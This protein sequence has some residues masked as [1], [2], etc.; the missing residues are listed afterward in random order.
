MSGAPAARD[1]GAAPLV[2]IGDVL[3]DRDVEGTVERL[4][5]DAPVPVLDQHAVRSRPGGAG[6]AAALA[7]ADG[8]AR[9]EVTL[10]TALAGDDAGRELA[11]LLAAAG[12][13]VVDL[14][15]TGTTPE[16][17]R[18]RAAGRPLLRVDRGGAAGAIGP[19]TAAARAAIGW[20][21]ALLVADY[22]RG[23]TA[24]PA[25]RAAIAERAAEGV[26]VAWDPHPRGSAPVPGAALV[27][28]NEREA[29][30]FAPGVPGEDLRATATRAARLRARWDAAAVCVTR[31]RDGALLDS[32]GEVPLAIPAAHLAAGD[33]CGAGDRFAARAAALLAD[34]ASA[35]EAV[36][37]AVAAASAFVAAGGAAS[38]RP[39]AAPA[40]AAHAGPDGVAPPARRP[41]GDPPPP[42][43]L[44][45]ALAAVAATRAAGGVVVATGGCFDLLHAGH[46]DTLQAARGL[47]DCL[48]VCVNSDASVRR[49]KGPARPLVAAAERAA[50][51]A[52]LAC[53]DAVAV[54]DEDTPL[55]ILDRLRP[56][57]WC[58]GGDYAG[59]RLP[60]AA[61]L[62]RWGGQAV[63]LPHRAGRS[64][65]R[66][67]E[68]AVNRAAS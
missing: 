9:R 30:G 32:G 16:K 55:A 12:V 11:A 34:G 57:I 59:A 5:P 23:V 60:E 18:L 39:R 58:K 28:P 35:E 62:A 27:T 48:V 67:I 14:G 2:V 19:A 24:A 6:L 4:S 66:L 15:L 49:L 64:T 68:E 65:T 3:L 10:V 47:G 51:L 38:Y 44:G 1:A 37:A 54:F 33:P 40:P 8:G 22:G 7:T 53:V 56:D 45:D 31:G 17:L 41:A 20:A 21:S 13:E 26:P 36:T 25:L 46:V 63:V 29:A 42:G 61:A 43:A 50:L 52:A